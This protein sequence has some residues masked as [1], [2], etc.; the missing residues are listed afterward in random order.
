[1]TSMSAC[2]TYLHFIFSS[3]RALPSISLANSEKMLGGF[4]CLVLIKLPLGNRTSRLKDLSCPVILLRS[5][6][7]RRRI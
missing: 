6:G 4:G 7:T 1:M 2:Y 5:L 3:A